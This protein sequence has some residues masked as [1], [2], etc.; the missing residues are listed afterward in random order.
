MRRVCFLGTASIELEQL[1]LVDE[2]PVDAEIWV[3]NEAHRRLGDRRPSRVFQLHVRDWREL[4]RRYL[5]S[6]AEPGDDAAL[7][8][9]LD[10]GCFGRNAEHV[11]YLRACG[12]PVYGQ[13]VWDDIPTSV[14]YPYDTVRDAVGITLPP[15]GYKRLWATSSFGYMAALLLTEHMAVLDLGEKLLAD[16][17]LAAEEINLTAHLATLEE[18]VGELLLYGVE[19][20]LGSS[21]ER[22]W[23][24][25]NLAYYLGQFTGLGIQITLPSCGSALLSAPHYA[26]DGRP[27]PGDP[28]HWWSPGYAAVIFDEAEQLH[29]LGR[30]IAREREL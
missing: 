5:S 8:E 4:E 28:D 14:R 29:R 13:R 17:F 27:K 26:L 3:V 21:R 20:P 2:I 22:L 10:A 15:H 18:R 9:G 1:Q 6:G 12:V 19:L 7:P 23:E 30:Y 25:P 11:E 16:D 24:W